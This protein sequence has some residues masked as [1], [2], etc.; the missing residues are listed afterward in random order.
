MID[1]QALIRALADYPALRQWANDLPRQIEQGLSLSRWG[2]LPQWQAVLEQLS[3][4]LPELIPSALN[5]RDQVLIGTQT[6]CSDEQR[7]YLQ[8]LLM[9]LHPWRKGPYQLFG[10]TIDTEW[11]SD[12]KWQ[13]LQSQIATLTDR[14]VLDVGCGNGYHCWRMLGEGA[15]R[16]IGIDPSPRFICQFYALKHFAQKIQADLPVDIL[17][18]GIEAMPSELKAFDTV[19]SMG[20]LYHRRSPMDHLRELKDLLRPGGQLVLETLVINGEYNDQALVPEGRYAKMRNVWFIPSPDTLLGW[21]RKCGF[22]DAS[23]ID[24]SPTT[25]DEQR[26]TEWMCF[27]S[28]ADFLD[29]GNQALTIEGHP[30]PVRAIFTATTPG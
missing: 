11:R 3:Q 17:P 1:Y 16:V 14:L 23:C 20:V 21:L 28:L 2:D 26:A 12:L 24:V 8:K 22:T 13:R 15:S 18:L 9:K 27:E 10:L 5:F 7:Q 25:S 29:P 4:Q 30:A 6:D 19:F